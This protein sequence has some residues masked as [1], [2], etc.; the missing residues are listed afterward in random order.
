MLSAHMPCYTVELRLR[1]EYHGE[2]INLQTFC[3][4]E[5]T[6]DISDFVIRI[7][8]L[9]FSQ[10]VNTVGNQAS[11]LCMCNFPVRLRSS[12]KL[13]LITL[14][15]VFY[16]KTKGEII[17]LGDRSNYYINRLAPIS[18]QCFGTFQSFL[19]VKL[20]DSTSSN[21]PAFQ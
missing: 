3:L 4:R 6:E 16:L 11:K 7:Y 10:P 5:Q 14:E 15:G 8:Y 17:E 18:H 12:S 2:S 13:D 20:P 19:D 1:A 9:K 21:L